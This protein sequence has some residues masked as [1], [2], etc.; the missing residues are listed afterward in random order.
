MCPLRLR[1]HRETSAL[2][3]N[4]A[5]AHLKMARMASDDDG[6][7]TSL[8]RAER[9]AGEAVAADGANAKAHFRLGVARHEL[10]LKDPAADV[11]A[12]LEA[13]LAALRRSDELVPSAGAKARIA[14]AGTALEEERSMC[15]VD[16]FAA[17]IPG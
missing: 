1:L 17:S 3:A 9:D 15:T 7:Q 4:R 13:A 2:Y 8:E 10:A 5:Q 11:A 6:G 14:A 12:R 16:A